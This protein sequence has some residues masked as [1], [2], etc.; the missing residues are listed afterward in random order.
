[1]HASKVFVGDHLQPTL[2]VMSEEHML[3]ARPHR[4]PG[5]AQLPGGVALALLCP[6]AAGCVHHLSHR[7]QVAQLLPCQRHLHAAENELTDQM[8]LAVILEIAPSQNLGQGKLPSW[9]SLAL[10]CPPAVRCVDHLLH[11]HHGVQIP[12]LLPCHRHLHAAQGMRMNRNA[13]PPLQSALPEPYVP[14]HISPRL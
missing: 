3:W 8:G 6:P 13:A 11:T 12:Q 9:V 10:L 7:V 14:E 1:M 5:R 4:C 2:V